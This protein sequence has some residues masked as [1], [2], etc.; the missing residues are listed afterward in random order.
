MDDEELR[1]LHGEAVESDEDE[2]AAVEALGREG[3]FEAWVCGCVRMGL[4][5]AVREDG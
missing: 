2:A 1:A 4:L 3:A 5:R